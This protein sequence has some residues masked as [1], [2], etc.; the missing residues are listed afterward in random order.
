MNYLVLSTYRYIYFECVR[1]TLQLN[2][3]TYVFIKTILYFIYVSINNCFLDFNVN[4]NII[5]IL[6][7]LKSLI[8][9]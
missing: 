7:I 8:N 9:C 5:C 2:K 1:Y 6:Y 3:F 4:K